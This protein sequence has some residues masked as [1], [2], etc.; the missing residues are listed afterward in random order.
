MK[1]HSSLAL[2]AALSVF[3]MPAAPAAL[4][5]IDLAANSGSAA[6]WDVFSTSVTNAAVTDQNAVDNDVT[7]TI[8]G[9]QGTNNPS[10]AGA[11]TVDGITVPLEANNDYVWGD[12]QGNGGS[13]LFEIQESGRGQL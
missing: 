3:A 8:S 12:S 2:V 1:P 10:G 13:I 5:L 7:L 4:L 6:G 11:A 9:I